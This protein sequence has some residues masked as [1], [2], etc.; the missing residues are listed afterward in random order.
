LSFPGQLA[1]R[2]MMLRVRPHE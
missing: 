1:G 2:L